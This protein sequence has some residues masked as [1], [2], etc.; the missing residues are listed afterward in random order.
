MFFETSPCIRHHARSRY[1]KKKSHVCA[2]TKLTVQSTI[3][4]FA[5][6]KCHLLQEG[7]KVTSLELITLS[8]I[9]LQL[10]AHHFSLHH[11]LPCILPFVMYLCHNP[12]LSHSGLANSFKSRANF[13][14]VHPSLHKCLHTVGP[15]CLLAPTIW[16]TIFHSL[17]TAQQQA[18]DVL[19]SIT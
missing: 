13:S 18:P 2:R 17:P 11:S 7:F 4:L 8:F 19:L 5:Q 6:P 16:K 10:D 15:Q 3:V 1:Q 12:H 9:L 14:S